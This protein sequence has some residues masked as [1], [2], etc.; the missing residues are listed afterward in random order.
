MLSEVLAAC[1]DR[2]RNDGL[3]KF[4]FEASHDVGQLTERTL[5]ELN[6]G[7]E[8]TVYSA[9]SQLWGFDT[10]LAARVMLTRLGLPLVVRWVKAPFVCRLIPLMNMN[11]TQRESH[12]SLTPSKFQALPAELLSGS[13]V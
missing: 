3:S 1:L 10:S 13:A 12:R 8:R 5:C 9:S 2:S 4:D 6:L 11:C 7:M